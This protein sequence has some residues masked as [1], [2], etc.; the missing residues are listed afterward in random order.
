MD[1]VMLNIQAMKLLTGKGRNSFRVV[2]PTMNECLVAKY[3]FFLIF[4]SLQNLHLPFP[5]D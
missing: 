2:A 5:R 3:L 1:T 4:F